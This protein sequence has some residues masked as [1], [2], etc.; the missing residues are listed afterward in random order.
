MPRAGAIV[1]V[2]AGSSS[3]KFSLFDVSGPRLPVFLKGQI[4]GLYTDGARFAARD[5]AGGLVTEKRWE[6]RLTHADAM[7]H[8][9]DFV[10]SHLGDRKVEVVGHRIAHGG[11]DYTAPTRLDSDVL[12]RLERLTPLAPLHQPHNLAPV[13]TTLDVAPQHPQVGCFDTAFHAAQPALAQAFALPAEITDRGVR[14]YG[15]HGLSYEYIASMLPDLDPRLAQ[16]RVIVAH[17]GNGASLCALHAGRS[18]ASTMGFTA[19]E[20]LP[21]GTRSGSLDPGVILYLIDELKMGPRD[22]ER[23]LYK[24][25]GL[26]GVSGISSDMRAL[27]ASQNPVL[28]WPSI[29][30]SIG[31]VGRLARSPRRWAGSM[32]LSS[33]LASA[34]TARPFAVRFARQ[35]HGLG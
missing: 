13:R 23:L 7:R 28:A 19:V 8:L 34:S 18:I 24:Q 6:S 3:V 35:R 5:T 2:N 11:T 31:S 29:C 27:E 21:M 14:R 25:S 26:L 30:S 4:E 22:I 1:V 10:R 32:Q 12:A 15:F 33:R 17:L 20:G 9:F 16:A